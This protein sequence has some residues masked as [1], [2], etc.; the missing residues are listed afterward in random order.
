MNINN[1]TLEILDPRFLRQ[2]EDLLIDQ[3]WVKNAISDVISEIDNM[4]P[5]FS[6]TFPAASSE[7]GIY[8]EVKQVDWT[9]GFWTGLLWLAYEATADEKYKTIAESFLPQFEERLD[10]DIKINTHDLGFLYILSCVAAWKVAGNEYARGLALRAADHLLARFNS[11]AKII[12]AWGDLSDPARQG[13]MIIDCNLNLPLLFWASQETGNKKYSEAATL[14]LEQA[15]RYLVRNDASTFH[16]YY[17]D[18]N[19]G[20]PLRGDTHQ[21]F[22]DTS[23]WSRGQAWA[24]YG[25][26]LG[27]EY[28]N[29]PNLVELSRKTTHYFLNR[30]P[31]DYICYWDLIFKDEDKA[32]RDTSSSAIA[33]CGMDELIKHLPIT[34]PQIGEYKIAISQIMKSLHQNYFAKDEDGILKHGVYNFGRNMGIDTANLW[35]DYYYL[36]ALIRLSKP[37]KK[38]W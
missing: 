8:P 11:T 14:H 21:G 34:D 38:Y 28:T 10:K 27:F 7:N 29:Q 24:M 36:E 4:L 32:Y 15:T 12:Q 30:L 19:T 18:V 9:E 31:E 37:W 26:A 17:I 22:S 23:C 13:R 5:R 6:E 3:A 33:V 25:F 2:K 20:E 35:G 16:T 1:I